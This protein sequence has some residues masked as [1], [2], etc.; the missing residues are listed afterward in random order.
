MTGMTH[1]TFISVK[2]TT[3]RALTVLHGPKSKGKKR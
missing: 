2:C 3:K 1:C